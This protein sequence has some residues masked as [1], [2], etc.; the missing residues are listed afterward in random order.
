MTDIREG[1]Q[2]SLRMPLPGSGRVVVCEAIT[3]WAR[4]RRGQKAIGLAFVGLA[5]EVLADIRTYVALMGGLASPS[6]QGPGAEA[7]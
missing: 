1:E 2:V 7:A 4:T 6:D 5:P 3:R